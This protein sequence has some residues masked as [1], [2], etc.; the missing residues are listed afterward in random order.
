MI[1][2]KK[3][4][5]ITLREAPIKEMVDATQICVNWMILAVKIVEQGLNSFDIPALKERL[6]LAKEYRAS[7]EYPAYINQ[8]TEVYLKI[9]EAS[10]NDLILS[11][12]KTLSGRVISTSLYKKMSNPENAPKK[13]LTTVQF[14]Q[15]FIELLEKS[16]YEN[17]I[18]KL[19]TYQ[20]YATNQIIHYGFL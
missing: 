19:E 20:S 10:G 14:F 5:G 11:T 18:Q 2:Y 1:T 9:M 8:M 16:D 17:A 15:E 3:N 4:R 7:K 12:Y 13:K 6:A